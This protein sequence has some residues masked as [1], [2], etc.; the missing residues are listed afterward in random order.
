VLQSVTRQG[1]VLARFGGE[2]F[3]VIARGA[4]ADRAARVGVR[5]RQCVAD[6]RLDPGA[7][8]ERVTVSVGVCAWDGAGARPRA[9][10]LVALADEALYAAKRDGRDRVR[11]R[12]CAQASR[13][14]G[15]RVSSV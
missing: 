4:P 15:V 11:V 6:A 10:E 9:E 14:P 1:D 12:V 5:F 8:P 3:I 13:A 7:G 2:E